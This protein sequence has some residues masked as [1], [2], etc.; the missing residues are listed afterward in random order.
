MFQR[1]REPPYSFFAMQQMLNHGRSSKI[2]SF[3]MRLRPYDFAV[4][5]AAIGGLQLLPELQ[6][7]TYRI[8]A[9]AHAAVA[10]CDGNRAPRKED[11]AAWLTEL[12]SLAGAA[13]DPAEDVFSGRVV[14]EGQNYT[15]LEGLSEGGCFHLQ[16]ILSVVE[17]MPDAYQ[18]LKEECR[19][20][21][22]L[23]DAICARARITPNELGSESPVRHKVGESML[24][25]VRELASWVTFT[26]QDRQRL[27]L[28]LEALNRLLL[29]PR[30]RAVLS[31]P[32]GASDLYTK[33]MVLIETSLVVAL[34]TAI[35]HAIRSLVIETCRRMGP[36][37][38]GIF[39]MVHLEAICEQVLESPTFSRIPFAPIGL[40]LS[41]VISAAPTEVEPGY[42]VQIIF[43]VDDLARFEVDGLMG[44]AENTR[45]AEVLL[46]QMILDAETYCEAQPGFKAGLSVV[47]TCG[48]G[49]GRE[50]GVRVPIGN[51]F[52]ETTSDYDATVLSWRHD[53]ELADILRLAMTEQDLA[54]IGFKSPRMNSLL[55]KVSDALANRG[56]LIPHEVLE[57]GMDAGMI[58]MPQNSQ[59]K[60]RIQYHQRNDIRVVTSPEGVGVVV[61]KIS[62]GGRSPNGICRLYASA[63]EARMGRFRAVWVHQKRTWWIETRPL[64]AV[65]SRPCFRSFMALEVWMEKA[66]PVLDAEFPELSDLMSLELQI[67]PQPPAAAEE[68]VPAD[69][70]EIRTALAIE[71]DPVEKAVKITVAPDFWRG[72][73][74]PDN[75]AEATLVEG[76]VRG[77]LRLHSID[78]SRTAELMQ[79]IVTSPL[80]RQLHAFAPHDFRDHARGEVEPNV[81]HVSKFQDAALRI[82][83]GWSGVPKPGGTVVGVEACTKA[84]NKITASAEVALC[85]DLSQFNRR[86]LIEA[87]LRNNEAA[88]IDARRWKMTAS[89]IIALSDDEAA[90]RAQIAESIF[91]LNG[92]TLACRN[93]ME[94]GLHHCDPSGGL[95]VANIDLARLMARAMTIVHLGGYSD[96]IR[97]GAMRPEIRISPAGEVQID[98]QFFE[99]IMDP[100]GREFTDIQVDHERERYPRYLTVPEIPDEPE[101]QD[102][103]PDFE[104]A[105]QAEFDVSFETWR[106]TMGE[107]ESLCYE[108]RVPWLILPRAEFLNY[109][110]RTV[111]GATTVVQHM[112]SI[113]RANWKQVPSGFDNG[114]RQLWRFRR[115]LSVVRRPLLR[116]GTEETSDILVAPGLVREGLATT[117]RNLFDGNYDQA[118]LVSKAMQKWVNRVGDKK[119]RA[120]ETKVG[121]AME[122][123]GWTV[124]VSA[125]FGEVLGKA[126]DEDPGDI[127]V[128]A[129]NSEGRIVLLECKRLKFAKTPSEVA[130]QLADF[131]GTIDSRGKPDL[132][133][134]H[135]RRWDLAKARI[136]QF[137]S[138]VGIDQPTIE[139]ALVFSNPVPMKYAV[140]RMSA[141]LWVGTISELGKL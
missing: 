73:S 101:P 33:P 74:H 141:A 12:G 46:D 30:E 18:P 129:W 89:A 63:Q 61:R 48:F 22:K 2:S 114:D 21:L 140:D 79:Q 96:A 118:R 116:L 27:G 1:M 17:G 136:G 38:L 125:T 90:T 117:A 39:R 110:E 137:A 28:S 5:V 31:K 132:L 77:T 98:A 6:A 115:R 92:V 15:V 66:A 58:Y 88:E 76:F 49:R 35:G 106:L 100:V 83:L 113:P 20:A 67:D 45:Q 95:T 14:F 71:C 8:E 75:R 25:P 69:I 82:G 135:L 34:P 13:E 43:V 7:S 55:G 53:L 103:E 47:L 124:L 54:N 86:N 57:D 16:L 111:E 85:N 81:V 97:Y 87:A 70:E 32:Y 128:L 127:D 29:A 50:M 72:L 119:G 107:I 80:A 52:V 41:P 122:A 3:A 126:P 59:L 139:A 112:E 56:H 68:L 131:R 123:L 36:N 60:T 37:H 42:W 133:L 94:I 102:L 24:R 23:S 138:F 121:T 99:G 84:L 78:E 51:W 62:G 91:K 104:N 40:S 120:F 19:A 9:L 4:S 64:S 130:K 109:L 134:K 10:K 108:R 93:L 11:L 65:S 26:E 44:I 105:W